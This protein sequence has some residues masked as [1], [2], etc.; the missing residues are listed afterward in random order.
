MSNPV[1]NTNIHYPSFDLMRLLLAVEV[2][3]VHTWASL[4]PHFDWPGFIRAV[5]AFLAVS[6]FLVLKSF[7]NT[8]SWS[9][10]GGKGRLVRPARGHGVAAQELHVIEQHTDGC[11]WRALP[12]LEDHQVARDLDGSLEVLA[13][14]IGVA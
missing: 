12:L 11:R 8:G 10:L 13:H 4:D 14:A 7:A 3:V 2:V 5:P 9:V 1:L 6:G